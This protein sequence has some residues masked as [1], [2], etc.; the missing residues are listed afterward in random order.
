MSKKWIEVYIEINK[1]FIKKLSINFLIL[2]ILFI[3]PLFSYENKIIVKVENEIVT[4][5]DILNE[6]KYLKALNK[7]LRDMSNNEI[8][9]ISLNSIIREKIKRIEIL[10]SFEKLSVEENYLEQ[11]IKTSYN[12]LKFDTKEDFIN[13]LDIYDIDFEI[14]KEKIIIEALWN[15]IIYTKFINQINIDK[16]KLKSK[17]EEQKQKKLKSFLLSEIVFNKEK[18]KTIN[19]TFNQ[20]KKD[21]IDKGFE[22]AA[23]IHSIA[24]SSKNS[25]SLGWID[26]DSISTKLRERLSK[27]KIGQ[28]TN[29]ITIPG[30]LLI[31]KINDIKE[32]ENNVNVEKKLKELIQRETN[33]QL[34]QFSNIYYKK[35]KNNIQINEL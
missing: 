16:K 28:Y 18:N 32:I 24:S 11:L 14:F 4:S 1:M 26:E 3:S 30:G 2:L 19:E 21:I 15:E 27:I 23:L 9:K 22:N 5:I 34:N 29:P 13:Y 17:I 12:N 35:I 31:L 8:Y 10:N 33:Q 6:T 25:G 7:N 20:I